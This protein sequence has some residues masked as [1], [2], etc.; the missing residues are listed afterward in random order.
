MANLFNAG[1]FR[2]TLSEASAE[3]K[4][5]VGLLA[6]AWGG[7]SGSG[8]TLPPVVDPVLALFSGGQQGIYIAPWET[9]TLLGSDGVTPVSG[10]NQS[11]GKIQTS[12]LKVE[13]EN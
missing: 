10:A 7:G 8:E 4:R 12:T 1:L 5:R 11:V 13:L 3:I 9:A 2:S 6:S